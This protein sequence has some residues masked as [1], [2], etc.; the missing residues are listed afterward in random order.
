MLGGSSGGGRLL[1]C[2]SRPPPAT[3]RLTIR[4]RQLLRIRPRLHHISA[5]TPSSN[6]QTPSGIWGTDRLPR[7]RLRLRITIEKDTIRRHI[8]LPE[9]LGN[10]VRFREEVTGD[11]LDA[12][13][14]VL[15]EELHHF[16]GRRAATFSGSQPVMS[17]GGG[18]DGRTHLAAQIFFHRCGDS[19]RT[20]RVWKPEMPL[21]NRS[22]GLVLVVVE[23]SSESGVLPLAPVTMAVKPLT[24]GS[25]RG[26]FLKMPLFCRGYFAV[27]C[28]VVSARFLSG[29]GC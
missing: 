20:R 27:P 25:N 6:P 29:R 13:A 5:L 22:H 15:R 26:R 16:L 3:T 17:G 12:I 1:S 19:R 23:K 2:Q 7:I 9:L 28:G 24:S 11:V 10:L 18:G 4:I 8:L 14:L 21:A